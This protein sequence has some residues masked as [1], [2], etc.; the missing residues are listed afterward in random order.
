MA[1][2]NQFT[3]GENGKPTLSRA[4]MKVAQADAPASDAIGNLID[5]AATEKLPVVPMDR[6]ANL[7]SLRAQQAKADGILPSDKLPEVKPGADL[8]KDM[9]KAQ[10]AAF[11]KAMSPGF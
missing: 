9:N 4:G 1:F 3:L 5:Q 10:T 6:P 11:N 2:G 8:R 7:D